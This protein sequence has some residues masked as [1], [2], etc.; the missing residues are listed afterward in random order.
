MNSLTVYRSYTYQRMIE[1]T[2]VIC[3]VGILAGLAIKLQS[4]GRNKAIIT[5]VIGEHAILKNE[6]A[7]FYSLHGKWPVND[8]QLIDFLAARGLKSWLKAK[9]KHSEYVH[10]AVVEKGAVHY[11]LKPS[12]LGTDKILTLR[13]ATPIGEYSG[14]I[15]WV[16][17]DQLIKKEWVVHGP[18]KS[19]IH[20]DDMVDALY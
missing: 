7:F 17:S 8:K 16:S 6:I 9:D 19:N 3:I 11:Y 12:P 10:T 20:K 2:L 13:P 14:P 15:I 1:F 5:Q 4:I 18:D